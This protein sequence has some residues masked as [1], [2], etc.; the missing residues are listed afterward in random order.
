MPPMTPVP[1]AFWLP[2]PAPRLI[3]RGKTPNMKASDVIRIGLRRIR[4]AVSVASI[5]FMPSS[6]KSLANSTIRM[7]FLAERPI[8]VSRPTWK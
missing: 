7:A 1:I 2:D 3:A 8:V 4:D 6:C 5:R